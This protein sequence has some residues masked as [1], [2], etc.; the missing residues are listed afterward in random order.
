MWV[1]WSWR[2]SSDSTATELTSEFQGANTRTTQLSG[3]FSTTHS[4]TSSV[5]RN[6]LVLSYRLPRTVVPGSR[7]WAGLQVALLYVGRLV[8]DV[9]VV[10][11]HPLTIRPLTH[12]QASPPAS[13]TRLGALSGKQETFNN[14]NK[15]CLCYYMIIIVGVLW[16]NDHIQTNDEGWNTK[17]MPE[18]WKY[19]LTSPQ[20]P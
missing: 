6:E 3:D 9:T 20:T 4:Y 11:V 7:A 8:Q 16:S 18:M 19:D 1:G 5:R 14:D 13:T 17:E 12:H 2:T 15:V 10:V